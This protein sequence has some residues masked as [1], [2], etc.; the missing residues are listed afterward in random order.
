MTGF[1]TSASFNQRVA[2]GIPLYVS[3]TSGSKTIVVPVT[4]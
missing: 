3:E 1:D 4:E 2:G